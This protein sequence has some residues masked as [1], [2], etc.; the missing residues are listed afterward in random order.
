MLES[1]ELF[2]TDLVRVIFIP[3][4]LLQTLVEVVA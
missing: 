4:Y 1:V 3:L 2:R